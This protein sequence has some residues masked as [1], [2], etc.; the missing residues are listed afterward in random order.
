MVEVGATNRTYTRDY[1]RAISAATAMLLKV[2]PSNFRILGF[3]KTP[4]LADLVELGRG[5]GVRVFEDLGSGLLL[6]SVPDELAHEVRVLDS[7]RAEPSLLCFSGDK[8]L[9]GP[10][11]GILIGD[12]EL[13]ARVRAHPLYRAF[14]CDKLT[15]AALEAT[16]R[17]YRDGDPLRDIPTLRAIARPKEALFAYAEDLAA[18][19]GA[20]SAVVTESESFVG[21]GANPARPLESFA[22]VLPGGQ[23]A[24]DSL[25]RAPVPVFGRVADGVLRLDARTLAAED[26]EEVAAIVLDQLALAPRVATGPDGGE[27]ARVEGGAVADGRAADDR[28]AGDGADAGERAE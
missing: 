19:L 24:A 2:H 13:V 8:L 11:A 5:R 12:E 3:H 18:R 6:D 17:I 28:S 14:R 23:R 10:Q 16:L 1:E 9:G 15:L 25:R 27:N 20:L 7:V 26:P 4:S 21:S 22:V